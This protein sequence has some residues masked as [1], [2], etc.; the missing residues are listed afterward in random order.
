MNTGGPQ[1]RHTD[2]L[3]PPLCTPSRA[4]AG[5]GDRGARGDPTG[6]YQPVALSRG[7][8]HARPRRA[9]HRR[10]GGARA[11]NRG[12]HRRAERQLRSAWRR[13]GQ[14]LGGG[15][16]AGCPTLPGGAGVAHGIRE[17][18]KEDTEAEDRGPQ[19]R[20]S[21]R[22]HRALRLGPGSGTAMTMRPVAMPCGDRVHARGRV[23]SFTCYRARSGIQR[24][25]CVRR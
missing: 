17:G 24:R 2:R 9:H 5:L 4:A 15:G 20:A 13:P 19:S 8:P 23:G 6:T 11:A 21:R 1:L 12:A 18:S 22:K 14:G 16:R 10:Q 3:G 25:D 7:E